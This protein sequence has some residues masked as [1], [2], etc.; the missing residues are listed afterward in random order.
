MHARPRT[1]VP[2]ALL[3]CLCAV[4]G[5]ACDDR[6]PTFVATEVRVDLVAEGLSAARLSPGAGE[7]RVGIIRPSQQLAVEKESFLSL[8]VPPGAA[9]EL[10]AD[11]LSIRER[12]GEDGELWLS[13]LIGADESTWE[14]LAQHPGERLTLAISADG[15]PIAEA[16]L[17]AG[18]DPA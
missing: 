7:P 12:G 18:L 11:D 1:P 2:L 6:G 10:V 3:I 17:F 5:G 13:G 14:Q 16:D 4:L 9:A 15:E 8:V